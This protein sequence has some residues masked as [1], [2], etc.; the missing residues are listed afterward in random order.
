MENIFKISK[1]GIIAI[2]ALCILFGIVGTC[3]NVA[4]IAAETTANVEETSVAT[5]EITTVVEKT[6]VTTE[7]TTVETDETSQELMPMMAIACWKSLE[8]GLN[9]YI[10]KYNWSYDTNG[11]PHADGFDI[12][13]SNGYCRVTGDD[14]SYSFRF[15]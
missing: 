9:H 7:K 11:L 3:L 8:A 5:E 12:Y 10:G 15:G 14:V 13:V 1:R 6:T 2:L 4:A